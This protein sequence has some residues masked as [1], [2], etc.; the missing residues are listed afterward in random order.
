VGGAFGARRRQAADQAIVLG[1]L[2]QDATGQHP[3]GAVGDAHVAA[4]L[5]AG[6]GQD[7][8]QHVARGARRHG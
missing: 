5:Q 4:G 3:L 2:E 6:G 7:R 1:Q 8:R